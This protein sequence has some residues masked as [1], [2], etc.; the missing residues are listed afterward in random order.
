[1]PA[2][3]DPR[4]YGFKLVEVTAD[5]TQQGSRRYRFSLSPTVRAMYNADV[6]HRQQW[7]DIIDAFDKQSPVQD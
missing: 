7:Q 6:V 5:A 3:P 4:D 2:S 1:M